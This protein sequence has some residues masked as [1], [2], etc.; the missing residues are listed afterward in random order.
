M[1]ARLLYQFRHSHFSEKAR[2]AL[3]HKGLSYETVDLT[4]GPHVRVTRKLAAESTVPILVEPDG[5]VVQD[6]TAIVDHL[7]ATYP[8]RPSLQPSDP[9]LR[10]EARE[11]E[12][13]FDDKLGYHSRRFAYSILID[14][15]D[16]LALLFLQG[17]GPLTRLA[18][19]LIYRLMRPRMIKRL[20]LGPGATEESEGELM[21]VLD[22]IDER[23]G[24]GDYLVGN[25][26]SRADLTGAALLSMMTWPP[27]H[28][29][30]FPSP[31]VLPDRLAQFLESI[32]P[33]P[34]YAWSLRMYSE[35]RR[36]STPG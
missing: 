5:K 16:V 29:F 10:S 24:K 34:A 7:E 32:R 11:L 4:R 17:K 27:E 28:D 20:Q 18:F 26:F 33:R 9:Q 19:P 23:L 35:H 25:R 12:E 30:E 22:V 21:S 2:W 13:L 3:D 14:H 15:P 31:S 1:N 8:E 6:S 36:S